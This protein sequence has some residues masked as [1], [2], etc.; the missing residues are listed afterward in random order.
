MRRLVFAKIDYDATHNWPEAA[1][2]EPRVAYLANEHRHL[3]R[4]ELYKSVDHGDRDVEFIVLGEDIRKYLDDTYN[5]IFGRKSCED[6]AEELLNHFDCE[7]VSVAEDAENGA[8]VIR[9]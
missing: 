5:H 8:I 1:T 9:N 6:L 4:I 2:I 7:Q 3:F